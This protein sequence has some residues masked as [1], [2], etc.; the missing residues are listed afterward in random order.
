VAGSRAS[1]VVRPPQLVKPWEHVSDS[2]G[3]CS[4]WPQNKQG[5]WPQSHQGCSSCNEE[6]V[7]YTTHL[8]CHALP[9]GGCCCFLTAPTLKLVGALLLGAMHETRMWLVGRHLALQHIDCCIGVVALLHITHGKALRCPSD[10]R[11][12][13]A[14]TAPAYACVQ[15]C[16]WLA[17]SPLR[18]CPQ[19]MLPVTSRSHSHTLTD[20]PW[21]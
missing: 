3:C 18:D 13:A 21:T 9:L 5:C 8:D 11:T 7:H 16:R 19:H 15:V 17:V 1:V 12:C 10:C 4:Y 14:A 6:T 2:E 20:S